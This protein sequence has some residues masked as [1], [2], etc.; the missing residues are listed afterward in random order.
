M[1]D[2]SYKVINGLLSTDRKVMEASFNE[3]YQKYVSLVYYV[4]FDILHLREEAKDVTNE[5]FLR[6]YERRHSLNKAKSIKYFLLT[7]A[8]NLSIDRMKASS[9]YVEEGKEAESFD[10]DEFGS[11]VDQ[12]K[13]YLDKEELDLLIYHLL[14]GFSFKEIA[15]FKSTSINSMTSKY[16][17]AIKKLKANIKNKEELCLN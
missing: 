5:T 4:S 10:D 12:F 14:Y 8:R 1:S 13:S 9:K 15:S 7:I 11:F 6:L 3:I 17:R 2:V 16:T